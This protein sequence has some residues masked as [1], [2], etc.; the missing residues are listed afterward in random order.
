MPL[1]LVWASR[2]GTAELTA[3][4]NRAYFY[5]TCA[6]FEPG[7]VSRRSGDADLGKVAALAV[8]VASFSVA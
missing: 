7:T 8:I 6:D 5:A 1:R 3:I 2:S 4:G